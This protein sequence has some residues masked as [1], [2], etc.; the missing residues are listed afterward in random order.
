MPGVG[1]V[2]N[3]MCIELK[4][5]PMKIFCVTLVILQSF[6][7]DIIIINCYGDGLTTDK[8]CRHCR[9]CYWW[10]AG[11]V[12]IVVCFIV[13][14]IVSYKHLSYHMKFNRTT[15]R[16]MTHGL[17]LSSLTWFL[18]SAYVAAKVVVIFRSG[19]SDRLKTTDFYGPQ[20]LKTGISLCGVVF[21]LF[22]AS[23]HSAKEN[24]KERMYIN[25]LATGVTFDI[26]DTVE[27]LDILFVDETGVSL[28][29]PIE[30]AV[31]AIAVINLIRPTF[32]FVVLILNHFGATKVSRELT[33]ANALVYIF[34]VN[35][36]FMVVRMYLWH[37]L[38]HDIS[39]FLVKNFIMIFIGIHELYEIG[40]E[41]T[42]EQGANV[43]ELTPTLTTAHRPTDLIH[44]EHGR[45]DSPPSPKHTESLVGDKHSGN[46]PH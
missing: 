13:S 22:V 2:L 18:Y 40:I 11:D 26:L 20:F 44:S 15:K 8:T 24:S 29:Y 17:P 25:S 30:N 16:H 5:L 21:I 34:L 33:A 6:F 10:I 1:S 37:N 36:P 31:L 4:N 42:R 45:V 27:F 41:K 7:M 12:I 46:S 14:F 38:N 39:V 43:F 35:V 9:A 32:S 19:V 3:K 23:H 28:L